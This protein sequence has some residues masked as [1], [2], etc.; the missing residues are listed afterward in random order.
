MPFSH[1]WAAVDNTN[2]RCT[3]S[4]QKLSLGP[5][6]FH[7]KASWYRRTAGISIL[8]LT[9]HLYVL[10]LHYSSNKSVFSYLR[11]H[12]RH[13]VALPTFARGCSSN[14]SIQVR[15]SNWFAAVGPCWDRRTDTVPFHRPCCAYYAG[16]AN[17]WKRHTWRIAN[18]SAVAPM[19]S[20]LFS[21]QASNCQRHPVT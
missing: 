20:K 18:A 15:G 10:V 19:M 21:S 17:K 4:L 16:S 2:W 12:N 9:F 5:T 1:S 14:W 8:P 3:S 6:V 7:G 13:N 11:I